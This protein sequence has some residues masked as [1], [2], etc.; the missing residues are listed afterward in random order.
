M[1]YMFQPINHKIYWNKEKNSCD[2]Y[3]RKECL[4][5]VRGML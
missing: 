1:V 2:K 3:N 5:R 4:L